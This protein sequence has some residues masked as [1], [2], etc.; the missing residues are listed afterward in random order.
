M[1]PL[2]K[3]F[4]VAALACSTAWFSK[5]LAIPITGGADTESALVGILWAVGMLTFLLACGTGVALLLHRAPAWV[6]V[7]LGVLAVPV[8]FALLDVLDSAIKSVYTADGWFRDEVALVVVAMVFGGLGLAA[9][10][11]RR[12]VRIQAHHSATAVPHSAS[13]RRV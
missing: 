6:R 4:V 2:R 7:A 9:A 1:T 13:R 10:S 8:S 5:M 12:N 3:S 11:A